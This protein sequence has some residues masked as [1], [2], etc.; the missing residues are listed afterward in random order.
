MPKETKPTPPKRRRSREEIA[1]EEIGHTDISRG[2]KWLLVVFF[3]A[4]IAAVPLVQIAVDLRAHAAGTR[5]S[6]L[7]GGLDFAREAREALR[8]EAADT[9]AGAAPE[10]WSGRLFAR[11]RALLGAIQAHEDA[12]DDDSWFASLVLTPMQTFFVDALGVG[13][14]EVYLGNGG[15][16]FYRPDLEHLWGRDFLEESVLRAR[17]AAGTEWRPA[18][19]PDP[20]P[21]ILRLAADL[22]ARGIRLVVAPIPPKASIHPDLYAS[23]PIPVDEPAL[24]ASHAQ[25]TNE[26]ARPALFL[27]GRL[28]TYP[29][30]ARNPAWRVYGTIFTNLLAGRGELV[31]HPPAVFDA[32]SVLLSNRLATGRAQYLSGD[33]HWTPEGMECVA[34]ALAAEVKELLPDAPRHAPPMALPRVAVSNVGDLATLLQLPD[35]HRLRAP[36]TADIR[37]VMPHPSRAAAPARVLLLGD[38]FSNIYSQEGLGWGTHAGLAEQLSLEL[39]EAVSRIAINAGGAYAARVELAQRLA[40]HA[41]SAGPD[42]LTGVQTVVYA[43]AMRELSSGD[44]K[45]VDM[46]SAP[47]ARP[48]GPGIAAPREGRPIRVTGRIADLTRPPVPASVPYEDAVVNVHLVDLR[49]DGAAPAGAPQ[50]VLLYLWGMRKRAWLPI[51]KA[52]TGT[53]LTLDLTPWEDVMDDYGSYNRVD[54][55]DFDLLM[56]PAYWATPA[57]GNEKPE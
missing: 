51:A 29:G 37:P 12:L 38:S 54:F 35:S 22:H 24:N 9:A 49:W 56:L 17:R 26:L 30:I 42:P 31:D 43:F 47:A 34:A 7:P 2:T 20:L 46:A 33:T 44:W 8:E 11:N 19:Q 16:L 53:D 28:Q 41:A 10:T 4:A 50:E 15:M 48:V 39:G 23:R 40:R 45:W 27:D 36:E 55:E 3:L 14:E 1:R 13:N 25:F 57:P 5:A 32:A 18:A 6:P 52:R 21:A